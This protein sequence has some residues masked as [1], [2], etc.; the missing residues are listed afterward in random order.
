MKL[1]NNYEKT[2]YKAYSFVQNR[3]FLKIISNNRNSYNKIMDYIK[4]F[5]KK[6]NYKK[7]PE[8]KW[9]LAD[10]V[11]KLENNNIKNIVE[12]GSGRSSL[13]F[14]FYKKIKKIDECKSIEQNLD[15]SKFMNDFFNQ[16]DLDCNLI[17]SKYVST[18][19]G[20]YLDHKLSNC[21]LLYIDGPEDETK[22]K[23]NK[24]YNTYTGKAEFSDALNYLKK[25]F[26]PKLI[27][28]DGRIDS[29]DLI[30]NSKFLNYYKFKGS[31][32]WAFTHNNFFHLIQFNRHSIF[33]LKK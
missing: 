17:D 29:V 23:R 12:I 28:F 27:I 19:S 8:L 9:R 7:S 20:G 5:N 11:N 30:L 16:I 31:F 13:F 21:D 24:S 3:R 6:T 26:L 10:L 33:E 15:F 32:R 4:L 18:E 2:L 25:G 22:F 1:D 14:N